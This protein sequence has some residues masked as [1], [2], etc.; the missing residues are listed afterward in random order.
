MPHS[1][2]RL[3]GLVGNTFILGIPDNNARMAPSLAHP[4]GIFRN[5]FFAY[6]I[7]RCFTEQP[8]GKLILNQKALFIRDFVP[9]LRRKTDTVANRIPVHTLKLAMKPANPFFSPGLVTPLGILKKSIRADISPPHKI[10]LAVQNSPT[11][12]LIKTKRPHSESSL[13]SI[14]ADIQFHLIQE[15]LLRRPEFIITHRKL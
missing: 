1:P 14:G 12:F 15:R 13:Y 5:D 11:T 10:G 4:L 3:T 9:N 8:D 6:G 2:Q 7:F